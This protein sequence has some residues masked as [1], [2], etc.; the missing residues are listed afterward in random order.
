VLWIAS[1]VLLLVVL[2]KPS[3]YKLLLFFAYLM[4]PVYF[5][6]SG[7]AVGYF[8]AFLACCKKHEDS[9]IEYYP[10]SHPASFMV[11][12]A[13]SLIFSALISIYLIILVSA[14]VWRYVQT[15]LASYA[16]LE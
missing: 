9:C 14:I 8:S 2:I 4:G 6:W 10:S 13:I 15:R 1:I 12:L 7:V 5:T 3:L 16:N 11:L